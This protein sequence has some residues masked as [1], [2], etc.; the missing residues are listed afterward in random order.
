MQLVR[1]NVQTGECEVRLGRAHQFNGHAACDDVSVAAGMVAVACS[2]SNC[3]QLF[4]EHDSSFLCKFGSTELDRPIAVQ[5]CS[6]GL[7][8]VLEWGHKWMRIWQ[9]DEQLSSASCAKIDLYGPELSA[10]PLDTLIGEHA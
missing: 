10:Q 8:V 5:V 3:I 1:S 6:D 9:L 4:R 7:I 2:A